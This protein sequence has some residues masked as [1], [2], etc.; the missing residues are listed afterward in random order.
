M[1][2]SSLVLVGGTGLFRR[3]IGSFLQDTDFTIAA[4]YDTAEDCI[5]AASDRTDPDIILFATSGDVDGTRQ[6]IETLDDRFPDTRLIVLSTDLSVDELAATL[7]AGARGYLLSSISKEAMLHSL[8]LILLGETVFP[9]GLAQAWMSGGLSA[10]RPAADR[11]LGRD[12][13]PRESEILDCLTGGASNKQIARDLGITE[14]SVKI[15]M[16]SL[17]RKIGV[18]NRTQAAL[19]AINSGYH[20]E[21]ERTAA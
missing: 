16:K 21:F 10:S 18:A 19:W 9:S 5:V 15:H 20:Q 7:R 11:S 13:T 12:L 8:T 6:A 3:G 1:S 4:E 17:I 2:Q 14:A